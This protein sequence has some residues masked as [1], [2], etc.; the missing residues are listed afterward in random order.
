MRV[1]VLFGMA[2]VV[3]VVGVLW[4]SVTPAYACGCV[5]KPLETSVA[6]ASTIVTGVVSEVAIVPPL[7]QAAPDT[8]EHQLFVTFAVEKYLKGGGP[9]SLRMLEP[10]L[11]YSFTPEGTLQGTLAC[12][13]FSE[14]SKGQSWTLF[15][16]EGSDVS[17]RP[18]GCGASFLNSSATA[19]ATLQQVSSITGPGALPSGGGPLSPTGRFPLGPAAAPTITVVSVFLA[20][21]AFLW[22]RGE[23]HNG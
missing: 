10:G 9:A 4:G 14:S 3:A 18:D 6:E 12:P 23:S 5:T 8:V 13:M 15:F 11:S 19:G 20:G 1:R 2:S 16:R 7:D 17:L 21:A 22:R